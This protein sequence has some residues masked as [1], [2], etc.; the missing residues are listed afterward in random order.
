MN[1][2]VTGRALGVDTSEA[3]KEVAAQFWQT[4]RDRFASLTLDRQA[5]M[6][7]ELSML[8][9][10]AAGNA[11][12]THVPG[13][14]LVTFDPSS[15]SNPDPADPDAPSFAR[16]MPALAQQNDVEGAFV[17]LWLKI[18]DGENDWFAIGGVGT[19]TIL[20]SP[21]D[22]IDITPDGEIDGGGGGEDGGGPADSLA[23]TDD[24]VDVS[25]ASPPVAGQVLTATSATE[26]SWQTP[27]SGGA[28]WDGGQANSN[29]GGIAA[30][31]GGTA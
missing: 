18:G 8:L 26:A 22:S 27:T 7:A 3:Q 4:W 13:W 29:Y 28:N 12:I 15:G 14:D 9:A 21:D 16:P 23:T 31:D 1:D 30:I 25:A 20:D 5:I 2:S 6:L 19:T 10:K 11:V 17:T 24:A